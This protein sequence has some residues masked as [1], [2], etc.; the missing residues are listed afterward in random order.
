MIKKQK[1]ERSA[2]G[3]FLFVM[4]F[5]LSFYPYEFQDAYFPFLQQELI[6]KLLYISVLAFIIMISCKSIRIPWVIRIMAVVHIAGFLFSFLI[7]GGAS[8]YIGE[9]PTILFAVLLILLINEKIGIYKFFDYYNKWMLIMAIG[10][11]IALA[12]SLIG[13]PPIQEFI[14]SRDLRPAYSWGVSFT[15]VYY[16]SFIRYSGYFDEPGAMGYWMVF[17]IAINRLFINNKW[18]EWWLLILGLFSFSWGFIVQA[19]VYLALFVISKKNTG[20]TI[21]VS[22]VV[23]MIGFWIMSNQ[24]GQYSTLYDVTFGRYE[25]MESNGQMMGGRQEMTDIAKNYFYENPVFG[26]GRV[27]FANLPYY[28]QDNPYETLAKDGIVGTLYLYFPFILLLYWGLQRRDG[29]LLRVWVFM[30]LGF[31][32]RPFHPSPLYYFVFYSIVY[33]YYLKMKRIPQIYG[34]T[35]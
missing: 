31:L 7:H 4:V 23:L 3:W 18:I 16:D 29:E 15:N 32:H 26:L 27:E 1:G 22:M 20:K 9:Y 11:C 19:I 24:R 10:G 25:M 13:V 34:K 5:I 35:A 14:N 6:L 28:M 12:L 30:T 8:N 2:F 21:L 17:A 33:M